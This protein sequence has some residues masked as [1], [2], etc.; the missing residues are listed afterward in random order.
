P[1]PRAPRDDLVRPVDPVGDLAGFDPVAGGADGGGIGPD[2]VGGLDDA[3]KL[4]NLVRALEK[5]GYT[6]TQIEKI[7]GANL[8]RVFESAVG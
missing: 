3:S 5:H 4:P 7:L 8:L 1:P 6:S 2:C